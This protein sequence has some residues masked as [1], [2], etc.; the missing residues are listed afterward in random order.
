MVTFA[1]DNCDHNTGSI[2]GSTMHATNGIVIQL[3]SEQM[4]QLEKS[5]STT[6]TRQKGN[7]CKPFYGTELMPYVKSKNKDNPQTLGDVTS[8]CNKLVGM[9][10]N[11]DNKIWYFI[12]YE[13]IIYDH[14]NSEQRLPSWKGFHH[15]VSPQ[16]HNDSLAIGCLPS[17][18]DSP[19]KYENVQEIL[20]QC[21]AK[22]E[23]LNL[24]VAG[25]V[26]YHAIYSK[27]LE[28]LMKKGNRSLR[29][30]INLRMGGFHACCIFLSVISK[31]FAD[32][33]LKDLI[34]QSR[35]MGEESVD[36]IMNGKH[37]KNAMRIHHAVAEAMT[38]K[39]NDSFI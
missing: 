25:L 24:N 7:F 12:R 6:L 27:A 8:N 11:T 26:L 34:I 38:R 17:I 36:Q 29:N 16:N 31:R 19:I 3:K 14:N 21:K 28:I 9:L 35:I 22:V 4:R 10:G 15:L 2:Q 30:F 33:G 23:A 20:L 18:N 1:Y 5:E 37:F 13:H 39:K 32:A